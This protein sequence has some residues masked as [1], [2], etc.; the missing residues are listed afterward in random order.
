MINIEEELIKE[1]GLSL[2]TYD[3]GLGN[4]TI[5]VGHLLREP[6]DPITLEQAGKL[7]NK[8]IMT[9]VEQCVKNIPCYG[10]LDEV[11]Q[12]VLISMMFNMG[13]NR[14]KTF[15]KFLL[16]LDNKSFSVASEEMLDSRWA[17]QVKNRSKKL[18]K[19]MK[20]GS[21]V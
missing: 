20:T 2:S 4:F 15:K 8:D 19:M 16:A 9:A 5:G 1:E 7:L 17:N 6:S 11:R 13:W 3:D 21:A 12:Y 10:E 18:A 14:L